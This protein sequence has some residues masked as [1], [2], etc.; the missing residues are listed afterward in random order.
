MNLMPLGSLGAVEARGTMTFGFWLP[1]V[2]AADGN[3]VTVKIIHEADQFLQA[4]PAREF[5]LTHSFRPPYGDFWSVAVP[6]AGTPPA[7]PGSAWGNPGRYVYRYTITN[8]SVGTLDW[9]IDP[10]AREFGV[11]KQS[12]FT[13]GYEPYVWS[14]GEAQWRTPAL[15][16]LI[17]Y[18][19]NIAEFGNDLD[20]AREL[21]AYLADLGINAIEIMPLSNVGNSV[22]WGYLPIGYFG[23]DERFGKRSDFQQLVDICHQHGIAVIVDVVYGHTGVDF[24]YYDAYT[25]LQYRDNPFMGPFAKDYFS[26]FG[27][28]TDF[29][30]EITRDY[31]FTAN[32]HWLEVYHVD[33][34][35]YDCVPNYWDGPMGVGYASLV[36]ETH[37]LT[38][39]NIA[40]GRPYWSRFDAGAGKPLRLVQMAEQLEA[41]EDVLRSTYSNCTWQNGT[42]GAARAVA[43][44]DRGR[45]A[46]LGLQ[47]GLFG[48]PD[49]E[50]VNGDDIP[51]TALQYI[52]NHDHER[53]LC[54]FG[55]SNPDEAGNPLFAEGD[56]ARWY[57]LQPYLIGL[58]MSKGIP[59]LW[60][61]EEFAENYFLP[62]FGM[63]RV[64]L[65]RPMRWDFFYDESGRPIVSLVRKLLRIRRQR[66]HMR[67]GTYF[68][69]NDWNR[70]QQFG[71]LLFAR[72]AGA[73]YTLVAVNFSDTDRTVPFWF[74]MA[75]DY[76]EELHGGAL[77]LRNVLS[78]RQVD[79]NIPSHYG[80]IWTLT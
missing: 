34:F 13:L 43:Q 6:I 48:Y 53:F 1:W 73:H 79:L 50:T 4:F 71:V 63:G 36:Y 38:R 29:N 58:L 76:A 2:S 5:Q 17:L 27:K 24:P 35:R 72:Y 54:N 44:G 78:L 30:R 74:P 39:A 31:F 61:C 32:H 37:Q 55:T 11:G 47:L 26:N 28:S 21:V 7:V 16:D 8:P 18:E 23:V 60:Q 77:D 3:V 59:M 12:A 69:F 15:A 45:L 46:D 75:G 41:P 19:V 40:A 62:D 70:Y 52:E 25:R 10:F 57:M 9:I 67:Q 42:Y 20:R 51:K 14:A 56:R 22:D 64:S 65:L 49:R 68:F 80:R 33:G 66:D